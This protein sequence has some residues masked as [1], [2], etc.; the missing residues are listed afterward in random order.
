M[1]MRKRLVTLLRQSAINPRERR[2]S[3]PAR[4]PAAYRRLPSRV[5]AIGVL[6][7]ALLLLAGCGGSSTTATP[8]ADTPTAAASAVTAPAGGPPYPTPQEETYQGCPPQGD[9]GDGQLN[10]LKNRIDTAAWQSTPLS[11]LLALAWPQG[12]EKTRRG[13]WSSADAAAVAQSEGRP[14]EAEGYVLMIRHEGPESP[15]CHDAA[16]RDYHV[17]LGASPA[18]SRANSMIVELAPRVVARNPGWGGQATLLHLAGHHVRIGGWLMLDQEHPEQ[19]HKTRGTLWEIHP[20]MQV[21]VEQ[22]GSWNDLAS[23]QVALG[24]GPIT[25]GQGA[26]S[27]GSGSTPTHHRRHRRRHH[28]SG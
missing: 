27:G 19:L 9:G 24:N 13:N 26:S 15:N 3:S 5:G 28:S 12:V 22:N 7:A 20:V 8:P 6:A 18:D 23:G 21:W 14:V 1:P 16:S 11:S 4:P 10:V 25:Q 2:A 17:W